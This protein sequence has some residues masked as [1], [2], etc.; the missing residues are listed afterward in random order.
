MTFGNHRK[1]CEW[2][3]KMTCWFQLLPTTY[4]RHFDKVHI[5]MYD[6]KKDFLT[7]YNNCTNCWAINVQHSNRNE[8]FSSI[9]CPS[10]SKQGSVVCP[11]VGA[12]RGVHFSNSDNDKMI[13]SFLLFDGWN[14]SL[15]FL[16]KSVFPV[17]FETRFSP[18]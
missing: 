12:V 6:Y 8:R 17:V 13:N 11:A 5:Q 10:S 2:I 15:I 7:S 4:T 9:H 18:K 16:I 1:V 14:L 3:C